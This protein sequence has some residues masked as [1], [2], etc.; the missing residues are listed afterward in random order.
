MG[1]EVGAHVDGDDDDEE[2]GEEG[3]GLVRNDGDGEAAVGGVDGGE[4]ADDEDHGV[5]AVAHEA[6]KEGA[7]GG[8][9]GEHEDAHVEQGDARDDDLGGRAEPAQR[10]GVR[11]G[12][13][14]G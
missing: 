6:L 10:G 11:A 5:G 8:E 3:L 2:D 4:G 9:L 1:V 12:V 7:D 14:R 13:R